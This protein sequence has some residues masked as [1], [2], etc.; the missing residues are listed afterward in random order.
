LRSALSTLQK[1]SGWPVF[2]DINLTGGASKLLAHAAGVVGSA[3]AVAVW[4]ADDEPWMYLAASADSTTA[5]AKFPPTRMNQIVPAALQRAAFVSADTIGEDMSVAVSH[6]G[7]LSTWRGLPASVEIA[8][9]LRGTGLAS[10]PFQVERL[11]GRLFFCGIERATVEVIPLVAL[12]ARE[13]GNSLEQLHLHDRLQQIAVRE[14]RIRVARDLHDGVLQS[15]TGIRLSLQALA[16]APDAAVAARDHL[17]AVARAI[18]I[19]Q[20]EL[21]LVIED[22]KPAT[23]PSP[24]E[25]NVVQLLEELRNRLAVEWKTPI[26]LRVGPKD[27]SVSADAEHTLRLMVRE[28]VVNALKHAYPS[29]VSV[30]VQTHGDHAL[31]LVISNDGRGFPFRGRMEH[32]ELIAAN[33]GPVSLRERLVSLGGTL[34]I[35]SLPTGS[36]VEIT[37]PV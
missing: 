27:L 31:R 1:V 32:D 23:R 9:H 20:R 17:L 22:L 11:S 14:D 29:R 36:N 34:A 2:V 28:A 19:E 13:V 3:G 5:V 10:A 35:E 25:G 24:T 26:V 16:D 33:A 7:S 15:L 18:A 8:A 6:A 12:A 30:D 21:R 4:E 37:L